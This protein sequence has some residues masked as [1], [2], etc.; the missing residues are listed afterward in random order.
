MSNRN[1]MDPMVEH[2]MTEEEVLFEWPC[3]VKGAIETLSRFPSHQIR[4][5]DD[6]HQRRTV[7]GD[8]IGDGVFQFG[9][10]GH[11]WP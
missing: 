4:I 11:L 6:L 3:R 10:V 5:R 2:G 8:R 1:G 7:V 9:R